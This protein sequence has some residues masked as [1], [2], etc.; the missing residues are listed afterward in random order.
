VGELN[1][2]V[3]GDALAVLKTW[4][5]KFVQLCVTSPPYFGL[6]DYGVAGQIGLEKT[7]EEYLAN[8][9]AIFAEVK[10]VLRDDGV[11]V[12]N[13]G[14]S[15]AGSWG[16]SGSRAGGQRPQNVEKLERPAWTDYIKRPAS[17]YPQNG[18]KPKDLMEM[19]SRLA[20]AL[21]ADGWWLR[22]RIPWL[23]RNSMPESVTDR[24]SSAV[25]YLFMFSKQARYYYD[26]EA[27]RVKQKEFIE[28][29]VGPKANV[30]NGDSKYGGFAHKKG[31]FNETRQNKGIA[32]N[33]SGR[34]RRNSD[35]FFES[36]QG[37]YVEDEEP[38]A[39]VV[40]PQPMKAAHFATFPEKLVEP[41][42]RACTSEKGQCAKCGSPH[43]RNIK[44]SG[45]S[46][47]KSWHDHKNDIQQ[48]QRAINEAKGGC[49]YKV[50][51]LGWRPSCSCNAAVVPQI[52]LDIFG[53]SGT[54]GVV[55]L[56]NDRDFLMI[57][58][59]EDYIK[60]AEER[61]KPALEAQRARLAQGQL[62]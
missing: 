51:T 34:N 41:F 46:I 42:I 36:W 20:M 12:V 11:C 8:L 59:S 2:I 5:D 37:L 47:G 62:I 26:A 10:R 56:D 29:Q 44:A 9:V 55:A 57:E 61:L 19:P 3:Q 24:P 25:E 6:R 4:P 30:V 40:N 7:P 27:V 52:V 23:K 58:L 17:S 31:G 33:S 35:S 39:L 54:T 21:Q 16:N 49:G 48:G 53:G 22:S 43:V 18:L 15:Y 38:L 28:Y 32:Y 13:M 14:D 45:G 50:E 1:A 60:I